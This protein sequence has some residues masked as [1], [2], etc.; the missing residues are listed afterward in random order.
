VCLAWGSRVRLNGGQIFRSTIQ[1]TSWATASA[2]AWQREPASPFLWRV[3]ASACILIGP[4]RAVMRPYRTW[5]RWIME[6]AHARRS[7]TRPYRFFLLHRTLRRLGSA[8]PVGEGWMPRRVARAR[9]GSPDVEAATPDNPSSFTEAHLGFLRSSYLATANPVFAWMAIHWCRNETTPPSP[10]PDWCI[11]CLAETAHRFNALM[12]P[13]PQ[14]ETI[15]SVAI[16]SVG[17]IGK[18]AGRAPPTPKA[19]QILGALGFTAKGKNAFKDAGAKQRASRAAVRFDLACRT[20]PS[21]EALKEVMEW[22]GERD[23]T[24]AKKIIQIGKRLMGVKPRCRFCI[25]L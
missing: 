13:A 15:D 8:Q 4:V 21:G 11:D 2:N 10:L 23:E 5:P 24:N 9:R 17:S 14:V 22:L 19:S 18:G 25:C 1:R 7:W 16:T 20:G 3:L 6:C 12:S